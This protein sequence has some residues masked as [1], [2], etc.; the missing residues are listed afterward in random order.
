MRDI[1]ELDC[2]EEFR[3]SNF[4]QSSYINEQHH[5]MPAYNMTRDGFTFLAMGYTGAKA[6]AF[7][8]AYIKRFN[9]MEDALRE[10]GKKQLTIPDLYAETPDK[11]YTP[12]EAAEELL[13]GGFKRFYALMVKFGVLVKVGRAYY[14]KPEYVRQGLFV[15]RNRGKSGYKRPLVTQKGIEFLRKR[16]NQQALPA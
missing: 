4:G 10:E 8:E 12:E 3:L 1:R 14:P 16:I 11:L 2:S 15:I 6:A 5:Q 9:A 13:L 7:K